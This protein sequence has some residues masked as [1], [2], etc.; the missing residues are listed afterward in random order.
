MNSSSMGMMPVSGELVTKQLGNG[1][2]VGQCLMDVGAQ[3]CDVEVGGVR[4]ELGDKMEVDQ[5]ALADIM[6]LSTL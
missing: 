5:C 1:D 4:G 3:Y 6:P 2:V